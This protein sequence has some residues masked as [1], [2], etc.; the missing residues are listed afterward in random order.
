MESPFI[1]II[2]PTYNRKD[3]L[4]KCMISL[5]N[6][7]YPKDRFEVIIVDDGSTDGTEKIITNYINILKVKYLKEKNQG[8][9]I[10][11]NRGSTVAKGEIIGFL[12]DDVVVNKHWI[13]NVIKYFEQHDIGGV[14]GKVLAYKNDP[15]TPFT[16]V[17]ENLSGSR[18][19]TCNIFYRKR[20]FEEVGGFDEKFTHPSIPHI[21]EDTDIALSVLGKGY[22]ILFAPD[23]IA[24]HPTFRRKP[25]FHF[26]FSKYGY[27]EPLL[28]KKHKTIMKNHKRFGIDRKT[29]IAIP[30]YYYGYYLALLLAFISIFTDISYFYAL[31][32]FSLSYITTIYARCRRRYVSIKDLLALGLIY[33][34]VPYSRVYYIIKGCIKFRSFVF[35]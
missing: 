22:K 5:A 1:S 8:P 31:G 9:A 18:Y 34:I 12:D 3:L 17:V 7:T 10:A 15:I 33:T 25:T 4:K 11:R 24:Y 13:E 21:R 19:L 6:Q 26:K 35:L 14:E 27:F 28:Y 29:I 2:I 23:V 30:Y 20:I 16:H 32:A